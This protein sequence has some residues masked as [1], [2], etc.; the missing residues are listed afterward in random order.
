[1]GVSTGSVTDARA[2]L[3]EMVAG[4]DP[5]PGSVRLELDGGV[6]Q[7]VLDHVEA[8][9]AMT[10]GMMRQLAEHVATLQTWDG[11]VVIVRSARPGSFCAGGHLGQVRAWM[12]TVEGGAGMARAMTA[13][14]D[15]ILAL[16][17]LSI[18]VLEGPAVGGGAEL[19]TATDLRFASD[20]AWI[21]WRQVALGV[22]AGWGGAARL[23]RMLGPQRALRV[24]ALGERFD[25]QA[26]HQLGLVERVM[27]D[28]LSE[29]LEVAGRL[30]RRGAAVRAAKAQ[31]GTAD[32]PEAQVRAFTSVWGSP[33]HRAVLGVD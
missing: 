5:G 25:A 26:A 4:R 31:V 11:A 22:A 15:A 27:S 21:E 6:A 1:M 10:V 20:G 17:Q 12:S 29:A 8:R 9:N 30:A 24:L 16:P 2:R 33:A 28:P 19:T 3:D 23:T 32:D 7:L 13:I 18:A 14:L